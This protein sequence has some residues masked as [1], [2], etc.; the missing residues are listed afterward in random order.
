LRH[1][2]EVKRLQQQTIRPSQL[3]VGRPYSFCSQIW[4]KQV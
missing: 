2:V 3:L 4:S 1:S